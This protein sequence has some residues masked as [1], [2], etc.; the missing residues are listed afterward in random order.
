MSH[1]RRPVRFGFSLME[2]LI[3]IAIIL[4]I[5]AI[6]VPKFDKARQHAQEMSAI[7]HIQTLHNGQVQYYS[8]FGRYATSLNELGPPASGQ[9][10]PAGADLIPSDL[11]SGNKGGFLFVMQSTQGG[12]TINANPSVFNS[13]GRRTF[14]SDQ[15]LVIRENWGQE[16]ATATSKELGAV[17]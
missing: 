12:Y 17:R 13:T 16:P 4:V 3:V 10:G 5:L 9:A 11:A 6:A 2:L 7:K 15:T 1:R 8:Q 14:Y